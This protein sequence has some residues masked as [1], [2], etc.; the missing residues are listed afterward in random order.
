[1]KIDRVKKKLKNIFLC[2]CFIMNLTSQLIHCAS[3]ELVFIYET[4]RIHEAMFNDY[5]NAIG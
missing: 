1:M 5:K 3:L 2:V 4:C